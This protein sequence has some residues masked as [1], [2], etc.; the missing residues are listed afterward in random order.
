MG[1]IIHGNKNFGYAPINV[2]E[3]GVYSFGTP[4]M[5]QGM[6]SSSMEIEQ[7]DT[8][9]YADDKVYCIV[10]GAKT[11]SIEVG[12][13]YI[14][15]AYAQYLGFKLNE[16]GMLTDTGNFPN[17]CLFFETE[18]EDCET[19]NSTTTLHYLYNVQGGEPNRDT[20]TDEEEIEG[21]ELTV[22]YTALDSQFVVDDD[23]NYAQYGYITRTEENASV[24]DTFKTTVLLP[25]TDMT[26]G[27]TPA[28]TPTYNYV[29]VTPTGTENP[30][31]EGW[32]VLEGDDYV[33]TTD[34]TVEDGTTYYE[35]VEA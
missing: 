15:S 20:D 7:S 1:R 25:T 9:I 11:R 14:D 28:P 29:E 27:D 6:V 34:T 13:R 35:R 3:D 24:Y 12:L 22:E 5:L 23:G 10:K 30:S 32:Y 21:A 2:S 8:S 33:L 17:H 19:G 26:G 18:E 31:E 4:V 16:N